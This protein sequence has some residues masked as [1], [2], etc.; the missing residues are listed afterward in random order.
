MVTSADAEWQ[1]RLRS[2]PEIRIP[3]VSRT[4]VVRSDNGDILYRVI[5]PERPFIKKALLDLRQTFRSQPHLSMREAVT[6]AFRPQLLSL[7]SWLPDQE[8]L[9]HE[10]LADF[11]HT[12]G[13]IS[14][15]GWHM[16]QELC[17]P[18]TNYKMVPVLYSALLDTLLDGREIESAC[19]HAWAHTNMTWFDLM[20]V[21]QIE[22]NDPRAL[23][24]QAP[25]QQPFAQL[26]SWDQL[27]NID[28]ARL[29]VANGLTARNCPVSLDSLSDQPVYLLPNT[30][31]LPGNRRKI[32]DLYSYDSIRH[33]LI[34]RSP[35]TRR[36]L[37]IGNV[38]AYR[39]H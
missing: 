25:L 5:T 3:H 31:G 23:P 15:A 11:C 21:L 22:V 35:L 36:E 6:N 24:D 18:A 32:H 4:L 9:R 30:Q 16:V 1:Q 37:N 7:L 39:R 10:L 17:R 26:P 19:L 27:P 8:P 2:Y 14:Y 12:N 13:N 29:E 34:A 38:Y 28:P 20:D 33:L